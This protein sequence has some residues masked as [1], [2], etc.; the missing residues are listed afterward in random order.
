[1]YEMHS[2]HVSYLVV[3]LIPFC[4]FNTSGKVLFPALSFSELHDLLR[5]VIGGWCIPKE[6]L[7]SLYFSWSCLGYNMPTVGY[8]LMHVVN[9]PRTYGLISRSLC[10][11]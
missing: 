6:K 10:I 5:I 7:S 8:L 1:M 9:T 11:S 2:Q 4:K 3:F